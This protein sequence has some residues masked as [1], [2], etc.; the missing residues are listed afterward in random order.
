MKNRIVFLMFLS[1]FFFS[2][3]LFNPKEPTTGTVTDYDGNVYQTVKI[4]D[5]W[6]MAENLN[7][8]H[9]NNG[10]EIPYINEE[11]WY[12]YNGRY[13]EENDRYLN[14]SAFCYYNDDST[15]AET[16]GALYNAFAVRDSRGLAPE[17]WH[18]PSDEE[19]NELQ[20]YLG[21]RPGQI[22]SLDYAGNDIGFK[23]KATSGWDDYESSDPEYGGNGTDEAGFCA[24]PGGYRWNYGN[25]YDMGKD[26]YFWTSTVDSE[27]RQWFRRVGHWSNAISR[28]Q[29]FISQ[30]YSVRCVKDEE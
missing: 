27:F 17:G 24:L 5:Q 7:V 30:G 4:G 18:V 10:D 23:L 6:W 3:N 14:N 2:C 9:F 16:Y 19:W 13:D 15:N 29:Y 25:C 28:D 22:D 20:I 1:L 21:M 26:A 11:Y 12:E 8:T